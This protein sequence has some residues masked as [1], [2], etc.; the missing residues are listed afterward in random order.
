[1]NLRTDFPE[2]ILF[3]RRVEVFKTN[4]AAPQQA[5]ALAQL[6]SRQFGLYRVNFDL[7]DCDNVL[8]VEGS[9][10]NPDRIM[11]VLHAV[12]YECDLL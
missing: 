11:S 6:L 8:R 12:G 4:V 5:D 3:K 2:S 10:I 1:M 7:D 9:Q